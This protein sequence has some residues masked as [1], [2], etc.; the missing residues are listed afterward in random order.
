MEADLYTKLKDYNSG[1]QKNKQQR[2]LNRQ[3]NTS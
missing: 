3:N 1:Q 2:T